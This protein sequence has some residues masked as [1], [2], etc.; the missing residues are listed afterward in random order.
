MLEVSARSWQVQEGSK[1]LGKNA[2]EQV[3]G[4]GGRCKRE[5]HEEGRGVQVCRG[6]GD[7]K[8]RFICWG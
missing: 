5:A 3:I 7:A 8:T 1:C 2:K 6:V 4:V